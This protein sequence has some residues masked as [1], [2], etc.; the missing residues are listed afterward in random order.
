[1][2]SI[3]LNFSAP[4]ANIAYSSNT[5]VDDCNIRLTRRRA[6]AV[7]YFTVANDDII[8]RKAASAACGASRAGKTAKQAQQHQAANA[9]QTGYHNVFPITQTTAAAVLHAP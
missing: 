3:N 9:G 8:G 2:I 5:I 4:P 1:M 7:I 6:G